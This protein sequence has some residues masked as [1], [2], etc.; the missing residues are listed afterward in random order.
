MGGA[1][2]FK[3]SSSFGDDGSA[4]CSVLESE[5]GSTRD[6]MADSRAFSLRNLGARMPADDLLEARVSSTWFRRKPRV[7]RP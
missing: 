6:D 1:S 5:A 4:A 7:F 3:L 2:G